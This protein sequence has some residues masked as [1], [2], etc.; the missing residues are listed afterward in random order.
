MRAQTEHRIE[1]KGR[2]EPPLARNGTSTTPD[3][4]QEQYERAKSDPDW[5]LEIVANLATVRAGTGKPER[6]TLTRDEVV[7]RAECWRYRLPLDGL[8][9]RN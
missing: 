7:K 5:R 6:L 8:A 2:G 3:V 1:V 4:N 9:E